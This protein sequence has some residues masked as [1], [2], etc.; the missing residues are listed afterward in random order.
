MW[1]VKNNIYIL[2]LLQVFHFFQEFPRDLP[3]ARIYQTTGVHGHDR[4]NV[5][6]QM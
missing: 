1:Q 5:F 4:K 6:E 3:S 2:G